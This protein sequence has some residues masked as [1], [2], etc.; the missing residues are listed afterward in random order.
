VR[1]AGSF[2]VHIW[3]SVSDRSRLSRPFFVR[4]ERLEFASLLG[5]HDASV[6]RII[7]PSSPSKL[8]DGDG[9]GVLDFLGM[10]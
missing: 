2:V 3:K 5:S 4:L 9:I 10:K 6:S 7:D 8:Q 1:L